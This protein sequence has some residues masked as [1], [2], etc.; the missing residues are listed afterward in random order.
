MLCYNILAYIAE[1]PDNEDDY[2]F[3]GMSNKPWKRLK[4]SNYQFVSLLMEYLKIRSNIHQHLHCYC[5]MMGKG[6]PK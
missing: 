1:S 3:I 4:Y 5:K 2:H 6:S